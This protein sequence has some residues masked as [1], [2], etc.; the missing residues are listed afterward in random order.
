MSIED[1]RASNLKRAAVER[2]LTVIGEALNRLSQSVRDANPDI[3][4]PAIVGLRNRIIHEYEWIEDDMIFSIAT[5]RVPELIDLLSRL[6]PP[7]P[8]DPEPEE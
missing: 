8:Q 1:Y 5:L 4:I 6:I 3:A 7:I 2:E